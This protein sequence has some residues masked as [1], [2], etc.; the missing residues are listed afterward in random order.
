MFYMYASIVV[1]ENLH[2]TDRCMITYYVC[3]STGQKP[4]RSFSLFRIMRQLIMLLLW[5][6]LCAGYREMIHLQIVKDVSH[7]ALRYIR[8][9]EEK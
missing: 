9:G 1:R 7:Q 3:H 6:M 8:L 2:F 4:V 5:Y